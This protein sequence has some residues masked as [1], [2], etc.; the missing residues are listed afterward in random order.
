VC[1][2]GDPPKHLQH[3]HSEAYSFIISSRS[4]NV[5]G[6]ASA[7]GQIEHQQRRKDSII[8]G[9]SNSPNA[10]NMERIIKK[11]PANQD[12]ITLYCFVGEALWKIQIVEQALSHSITLKMNSAATKERADE[13][14]K[15]Y[16]SYTLGT[17]IKI[18]TKE[19]L[20]DLSLQDELNAFLGLRN[21]LVHKAMAESH[22]GLNWVSKKEQLFQKIKSIS[23]KAESI[24]R[25]IQYDMIS[26][27]S[28]KGKDMSKILALLKLQEEPP[29]QSIW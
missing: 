11:I 21:W 16:Q 19:K 24:Q 15:K 25:E 5:V 10:P 12:E 26:F 2:N 20:Y 28:S 22:H 18:A 13:F 4:V 3:S 14:L 23:D 7:Q 1:H 6:A 9:S 17:A 8:Y 29:A 27:C